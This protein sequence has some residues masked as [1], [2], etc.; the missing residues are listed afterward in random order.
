MERNH[1][2]DNNVVSLVTEYHGRYLA[3]L[4]P[5]KQSNGIYNDCRLPWSS[6]VLDALLVYFPIDTGIPDSSPA[7]PRILP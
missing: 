2:S 7:I 3:K 6:V 4:P 1:S 5:H